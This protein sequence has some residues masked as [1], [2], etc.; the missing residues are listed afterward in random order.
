MDCRHLAVI[1]VQDFG[2]RLRAASRERLMIIRM[3]RG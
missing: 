2:E 3:V 1:V